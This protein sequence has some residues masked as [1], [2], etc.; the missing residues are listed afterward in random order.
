MAAASLGAGVFNTRRAPCATA[1]PCRCRSR[2]RSLEPSPPSRL[3]SSRDTDTAATDGLARATP[4]HDTAR[5]LVASS[6]AVWTRRS[7]AA[8][9]RPYSTNR[10]S[11]RY[12]SRSVP[13]ACA[14]QTAAARATHLPLGSARMLAAHDA[15]FPMLRAAR[16]TRSFALATLSSSRHR[17]THSTH[18]NDQKRPK[19][20][21]GCGM[22]SRLRLL[23]RFTGAYRRQVRFASSGAIVRLTCRFYPWPG[24]LP[25][26]HHL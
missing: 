3:R 10:T 2:P 20:P 5:E 18:S 15:R 7:K 24:P 1:V 6:V 23:R 21:T 22:T 26:L 9:C 14:G 16:R 19:H 13:R 11:K 12:S 8:T 4:G 25:A 17:S